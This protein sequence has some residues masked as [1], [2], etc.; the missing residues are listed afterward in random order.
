M[1]FVNVPPAPGSSGQ[2][3]ESVIVTSS[4]HRQVF[5]IGSP[6]TTQM[7]QVTSS[8][9]LWVQ[10]SN[11]TTSVTITNPTSA[12]SLSSVHTVTAT[13]ATNPWSSAPSF[14]IPFVSASSGSL[15]IV[16]VPTFTV[17]GTSE[18]IA[19]VTTSGGLFVHLTNQTL[20]RKSVV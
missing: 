18:G 10:I 16:G 15:Q 5:N 2:N 1:A 12:V 20:D 3:I 17:V 9:G 14:N 4:Q 6:F 8:G 11:G 13:A 19:P 7:A